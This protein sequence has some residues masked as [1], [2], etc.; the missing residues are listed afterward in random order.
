LIICVALDKSGTVAIGYGG[1]KSCWINNSWANLYF[2]AIPVAISIIW[3]AVFFVLIVKGIKTTI[4]Q[5]QMVESQH[6]ARKDLTVYARIAVL[7]GFTWVF[8]FMVPF[9]SYYLM[10]PFV[11]LN[12]L[13]G[14]YIAIAFGFTRRVRAMYKNIGTKRNKSTT[15]NMRSK[16]TDDT[17]ETKL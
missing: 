12:T 2:F 13:Q 17:C 9:T 5:S 7:M 11:I 8:G 3:N 15:S 6:Q 10:Y 14:L 1:D 16:S 4:D